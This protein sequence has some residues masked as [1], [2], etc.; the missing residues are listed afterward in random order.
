MDNQPFDVEDLVSV[1]GAQGIWTIV[2][3]RDTEPKYQIQ[4][5]WNAATVRWTAS[6]TLSLI[7]RALK[8]DFEF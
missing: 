7:Q 1:Q 5:G 8:R 6:E 3:T 4:Y 2:G